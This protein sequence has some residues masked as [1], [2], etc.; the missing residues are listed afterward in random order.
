MKYFYIILLEVIKN[1][2]TNKLLEEKNNR[3]NE[4]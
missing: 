1:L 4:L 2:I 3:K